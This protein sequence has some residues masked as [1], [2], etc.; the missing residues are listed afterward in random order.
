MA[1]K[2]GLAMCPS[3]SSYMTSLQMSVNLDTKLKKRKCFTNSQGKTAR[4]KVFP[5]IARS[6]SM[7]MND[8]LLTHW[9]ETLRQ[10]VK[11]APHVLL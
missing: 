8:V 6:M 7:L 5:Q 2:L 11:S 3:R 10:L 4:D 1:G 9:Y